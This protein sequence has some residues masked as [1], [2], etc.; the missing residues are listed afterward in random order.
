MSAPTVRRAVPAA[1]VWSAGSW[2]GLFGRLKDIARLEKVGQYRDDGRFV[3]R[4]AALQAACE[5]L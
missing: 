5:C 2:L 4:C 1:N 3:F